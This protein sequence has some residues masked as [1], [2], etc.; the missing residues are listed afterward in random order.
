MQISYA[1]S[2]KRS[3]MEIFMKITCPYCNNLFN[4][5]LEKCPHCGAANSGV[6]RTAKDQPTTIEELQQW[7]KERG[8]PPYKVTRFFIGENYKSPRAF[9]IYK[10]PVTQNFVVYK[11]KDS[12]QRAIRYEGTDEA[13]AVNELYQRLKQEILEQKQANI[14]KRNHQ[15]AKKSSKGKKASK[16]RKK[17]GI[18]RLKMWL[19]FYAVSFTM[20]FLLPFFIGFL[21]DPSK[22]GY[23]HYQGKDYYHITGHASE[24]YSYNYSYDDWSRVY[25]V[26]EELKHGKTSKDFYYTPTWDASTQITDFK[27][28]YVYKEYQSEERSIRDRE[29]EENNK[30]YDND[31]GYNWDSNDSWNSNNSNWDSDW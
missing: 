11:N 6:V 16:G 1:T 14:E 26:P 19:I 5:T 9:G 31:S 24:W 12:G 2:R 3:G 29:R 30:R 20:A 4:D 10:D 21:T 27:D 25:E 22:D 15:T 23:Y 8:L 28:S 13:Y 17:S 7:Y 18:S